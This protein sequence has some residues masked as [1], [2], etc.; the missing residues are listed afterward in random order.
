MPILVRPFL[1]LSLLLIFSSSFSQSLPFSNYHTIVSLSHSLSLR[2][3]TLRESR[4]DHD[5]AVRARSMARNLERGLGLGFYRLVW[6]MGWDYSKNYAWRNLASFETLGTL[7]SDTNELLGALGE[8]TRVNSDA[9]RVAWFGRNYNKLLRLSKSLFGRLLEVFRQP[10]PLRE[11]VETLQ[12]EI[13][14]GDLVR[15]CL[16]LGGNDLNDLVR[17]FKDVLLQYTS[18]STRNT[19]L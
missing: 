15:D 13:V 19:D 7:S 3:A 17:V 1:L 18:A 2:V 12:K 4:G 5:G 8:L 9:E 6:N 11:V 16:E 10:G 14:E